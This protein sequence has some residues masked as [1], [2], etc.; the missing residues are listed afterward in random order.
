ML[1]LKKDEIEKNYQDTSI[2]KSKSQINVERKKRIEDSV[3]LLLDQYF[4]SL[5]EKALSIQAEEIDKLS[6]L[7]CEQYDYNYKILEEMKN[8]IINEKSTSDLLRI[9]KDGIDKKNRMC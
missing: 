3:N 9:L 5:E 8:V 7:L 6:A 1:L 4:Y 2:L